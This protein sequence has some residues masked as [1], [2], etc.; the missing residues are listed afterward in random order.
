[1][2]GRYFRM[3]YQQCRSWWSNKSPFSR[4]IYHCLPVLRDFLPAGFLSVCLLLCSVSLGVGWGTDIEWSIWQYELPVCAY[5]HRHLQ[6]YLIFSHF[7]SF[8]L[9]YYLQP[10]LEDFSTSVALRIIFSIIVW[11]LLPFLLPILLSF[12]PDQVRHRSKVINL[13]EW[14]GYSCLSSRSQTREVLPGVIT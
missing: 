8:I 13:V 10:N 7:R 12:S 3:V 5:D 2:C 9:L 11:M 6:F 4:V 1:M 14:A